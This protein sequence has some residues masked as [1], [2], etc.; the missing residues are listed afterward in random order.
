MT[1]SLLKKYWP[2][3]SLAALFAMLLAA[4]AFIVATLPPRTIVMA[5]GP[6]G[7]GNYELGDRYREILAQSGVEL[8]L[9]PTSGSVENLALLRD[10]KSGVSVGLIQGGTAKGA[11]SPGVE[12]LGF[13]GYEPLWL[14]FRSE[15]GGNIRALAGRRVSIGPEGS[16]ARA[17]ALE[18]LRRT[19]IEGTFGEVLGFPPEIAAEK[20]L[21]GEIDAALIVTG[22]HS[23]AVQLL[24]N[25]KG[26]DL[27]SFT[28]ADA[29]VALYPFLTK[30]V[31]PSGILDL[32]N[33]RPAADIVLVAPKSILGVRSDLHSAMQYLLL[34]AATNIH[35]QSGIFEKAEQF[36]IG[37]SI[38]LP[39]SA[40]AERFYK[41]GRPFLQEHLP[42]WI[43][44]LIERALFIMIPLVAIVYPILKFLPMTYDWLMRSK[45]QRLYGEMRSVEGVMD[46]DTDK[47]DARA[48]VE[49]ID[50]LEQRAIHLRLPPAYGSSLYTM[51]LHIGLI[52]SHLQA[53]LAH[54]INR[55][56]DGLSRREPDSSR[57]GPADG[58]AAK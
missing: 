18:L 55:R 23:P 24:I 2:F 31:L 44:V 15:I 36:P 50:Q 16:G 52:R 19:K 6:R 56:E 47:L 17:L 25:A 46:N 42:F 38:D 3:L 9:L 33:G 32:W 58:K 41:S 7:G 49:Q 1:W 30:L 13:V 12:S 5:T 57:L 4:G 27:A 53:V 29:L 21:A 51:R 20:L 39:L 26:V 28:H 40:E 54:E 11:E 45:I 22:W 37:E 14:F 34:T 43:A 10:P 48:V 8:K 35:A